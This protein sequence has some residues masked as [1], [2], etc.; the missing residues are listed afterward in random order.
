MFLGLFLAGVSMAAAQSRPAVD[1]YVSELMKA[2]GAPGLALAVVR[3]GKTV[4][5]KGYGM[6]DV[7]NG[8]KATTDTVFE[9][10]SVTKQFT[11]ALV[12]QLVEAGKV[13]L[14]EPARSYLPNL[15]EAWKAV[16]VRQLLTHTSG[17]KSYTDL[18]SFEGRMREPVTN[19]DLLAYIA[20]EKLEFEPGSAWNYSNSGYFLLGM[21][22]ERVTAKPYRQVL[23]DR[24]LKPLGMSATLMNDPAAIVK[25]RARGYEPNPKTGPRNATWID[26]SWPFSA[27]AL[28]GTVK[29]MAKWDA[30]LYTDSPVKQSSWKMAW[31]P[32]ELRSG[33]TFPYGFG[34]ALGDLN[35]VATVEHEGGIPGFNSMILR[36]PSKKL[37]VIVLCNAD[38]GIANA[39]A[40][41]VAGLVDPSLKVVVKPIQDPDPKRTAA[42]RALFTDAIHGTLK[43]E[44][45][46]ES[47]QKAIFPDKAGQAHQVL[48]AMGALDQFTLVKIDKR[49]G[50]SVRT[51][52]ASFRGGKVRVVVGTDQAG[53][54][55]VFALRPE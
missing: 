32:V 55:A 12:L 1:R 31:T 42:E 54:I 53:K 33:E 19:A 5:A 11:A 36:V 28:M 35:G 26:M 50:M 43:E 10:G 21:L 25:H 48:S 44:A 14:D 15:P 2:R 39:A 9:L 37:T 52:V 40:K 29:D 17:I 23:R 38:P 46:T 30:A 4:Y 47:L 24:I 41:G 7:E 8:V 49:P 6:S 51:Y 16:T 22:I 34:W 20:P 45:F 18:P 3:G 27:G 13:K